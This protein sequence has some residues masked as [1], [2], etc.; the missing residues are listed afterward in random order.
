MGYWLKNGKSANGFTLIE[1]LVVIGIIAVLIGILVPTLSRAR[2]YARDVVCASNVRQISTALLLYATEN[3][4]FLPPAEDGGPTAQGPATWHVRL[5]EHLMKRPFGTGPY[6]GDDGTYAYLRGTVFECPQAAR[7]R[8]GGFSTA[9]H[10]NNGYALNISIVGNRG[11]TGLSAAVQLIRVRENK[12][13]STVNDASRTVLLTDARGFYVEYFDRGRAL[14][15]MDAG[16]SNAGGM[17]AALGR[18]G[19]S[20]GVLRK[21]ETWN[22]A[23]VDGSVR[24]YRFAEVPGTPDTYYVVGS[25]LSPRQLLNG[26]DISAETKR[27][28]VGKK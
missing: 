11:E 25:R 28:W 10:R 15:S 3:R 27:F 2:S 19:S 5:W 24:A 21:K 1:L 26:S 12:K 4:Q 20:S 17:L 18:H 13:L 14:N 6:A 8:V 16:I 22:I 23:S 7:S 9:D